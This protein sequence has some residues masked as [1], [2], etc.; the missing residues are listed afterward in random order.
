MSLHV[1]EISVCIA[2][3]AESDQQCLKTYEYVFAVLYIV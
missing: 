3:S 1:H 2:Y